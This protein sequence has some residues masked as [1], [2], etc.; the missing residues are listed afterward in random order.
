MT[1]EDLR[2]TPHGDMGID[3]LE[4]VKQ[5]QNLIKNN[6]FSDATALLKTN[7]YTKGF[8]ASLFN[9]MQEKIKIIQEH[10]LNKEES[11][12]EEVFSSTEPT[13]SNKKFWLMDY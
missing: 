9:N 12:S 4:I 7:G 10:L 8:R 11:D 2:F 3:D 6:E 13:D 1:I 5:H